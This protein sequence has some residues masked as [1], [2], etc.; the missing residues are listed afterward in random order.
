VTRLPFRNTFDYIR[1]SVFFAA[2][3]PASQSALIEIMLDDDFAGATD[4]GALTFLYGLISNNRYSSVLQLG[5]WMGFSAIVLADAL[6]RSTVVAPRAVTFDTVE[7]DTSAHARARGFVEL[8]GL[9]HWVRFIDGSTLEPPTLDVLRLEYDVIYVD[10]SHGAG[11]TEREIEMYFP[12]LRRNG[13]MLFHDSSHHAARW[14]PTRAG[15]VRKAI[16]AWIA[17]PG[18]PKEYV[19][20]EKPFWSSECGL[21]LAR[22]S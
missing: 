4:P 18:G 19:F 12:R 8:A 20:L 10:S 11:D 2:L 16:D 14:D 17:A 6:R 3:S 13:V 22:K 5:T 21:F 9:S 1:A 15:G 7:A